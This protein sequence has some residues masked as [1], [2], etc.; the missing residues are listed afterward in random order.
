MDR[1]SGWKTG[2]EK[3]QISLCFIDAKQT[4]KT[5]SVCSA[6]DCLW[7]LFETLIVWMF[8]HAPCPL[9]AHSF[10]G[11][12][13]H[14]HQRP[15]EVLLQNTYYCLGS[16][17]E[18]VLRMEWVSTS[19]DSSLLFNFH[20]KSCHSAVIWCVCVLVHASFHIH[21]W[22]H[23][24]NQALGYCFFP[25]FVHLVCQCNKSLWPTD[26]VLWQESTHS[27]VCASFIFTLFQSRSAD[28]HLRLMPPVST[29]F[30]FWII[31]YGM[32]RVLTCFFTSH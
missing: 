13:W 20:R 6:I 14:L 32:L 17:L 31:N 28:F 19:H 16:L 4:S 22:V 2:N 5:T 12:I 9:D 7:S 25:S 29:R 23:H 18:P 26:I 3:Q 10:S 24:I 15:P 21:V 30:F 11:W 1:S 27:A 8:S